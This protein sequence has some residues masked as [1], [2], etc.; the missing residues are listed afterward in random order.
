MS[1]ASIWLSKNTVF[2]PRSIFFRPA[3]TLAPFRNSIIQQQSLSQMP[4]TV[5]HRSPSPPPPPAK[6]QK[7][8]ARSLS[9][10]HPIIPELQLSGQSEPVN[11]TTTAETLKSTLNYRNAV[12]L[13]PMVRSGTCELKIEI[14][15]NLD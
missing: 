2:L 4:S 7:T 8:E 5:I 13:A 14:D 1:V 12:V 6:R 10:G 9:D 15:L 11:H 3:S